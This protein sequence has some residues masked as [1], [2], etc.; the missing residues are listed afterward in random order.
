MAPPSRVASGS[1]F[2][3]GDF[4][5]GDIIFA[6]L[7]I[8]VIIGVAV[9]RRATGFASVETG[10]TAETRRVYPSPRWRGRVPRIYARHNLASASASAPS[11]RRPHRPSPARRDR[12]RG[13]VGEG[14]PP[15]STSTWTIS[16][17]SAG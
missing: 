12:V 16:P 7:P 10:E 8:L 5:L 14:R 3:S 1:R 2:A 17:G 15:S 11:R 9:L 6:T 4:D 13:Q